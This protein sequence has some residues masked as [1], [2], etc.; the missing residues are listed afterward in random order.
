MQFNSS[1]IQMEWFENLYGHKTKMNWFL[2]EFALDYYGFI[3]TSPAL[4]EYRKQYADQQIA[5]YCTYFVRRL[6][7]SMLKCFRRRTKTVIFYRDY[8]D[9]FYP[10]HGGEM[11]GALIEVAMSVYEKMRHSCKNCIHQCMDDYQS[12]CFCFEEYEG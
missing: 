3:H 12:R 2:L 9:D 6:K 4:K 10:H 8:A 7:D 11:N 5:Q 1:P